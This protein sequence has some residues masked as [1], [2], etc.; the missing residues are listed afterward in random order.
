MQAMKLLAIDTATD[1]CSVAIIEDD[2]LRSELTAMPGQTHSKHL[3]PFIASVLDAAALKLTALDGF[4]VSLGPGSFTGVRIG[5]STVKG[6]AFSLGKPVVGI[7][8]LAALAWQCNESS[9][10]ICPMIDAR[11]KQVYC[12]RYRFNNSELQPE[13]A[14]KAL[15][16]QEAL[17]GID[18]PCLFVGTGARI[19][20]EKIRT[21]LGKLAHFPL[22][23][24]HTLRASSVAFLSRRRFTLGQYG[25]VASLAPNYIRKSDAERNRVMG[26]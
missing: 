4:A 22:E 24:R 21:V 14:E 12:G 23:G 11:K 9:G 10:L 19:Y 3:M 26:T 6:L 7:S 5:I 18:E 8:S 1:S 25:D 20:Q 2:T 15:D 17:N 16:P 13:G